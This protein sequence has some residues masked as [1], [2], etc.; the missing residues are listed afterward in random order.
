MKINKA[1]NTRQAAKA[2][3][4]ARESIMYLSDSTAA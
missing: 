3:K 4:S 2:Q 1:L